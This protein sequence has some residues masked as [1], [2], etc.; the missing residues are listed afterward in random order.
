M[1]L[2]GDTREVLNSVSRIKVRREQIV[3]H[4]SLLLENYVR[5][6]HLIDNLK[7]NIDSIL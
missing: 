5:V 4:A 2:S 3:I 6:F 7:D 1:L